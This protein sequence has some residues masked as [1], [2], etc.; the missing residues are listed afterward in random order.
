MKYLSRERKEEKKAKS[1]KE[2]KSEGER[3]EKISLES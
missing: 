3:E 2:R 1:S